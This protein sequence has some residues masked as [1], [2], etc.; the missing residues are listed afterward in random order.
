[1]GRLIRNRIVAKNIYRSNLQ[2]L[3]N[4]LKVER[5]RREKLEAEKKELEK[6]L[7]AEKRET[8]RLTRDLKSSQENTK[9]EMR[10]TEELCKKERE[11][12]MKALNPSPGKPYDELKNTEAMKER[13]AKAVTAMRNIAGQP[14]SR[15]FHHVNTHLHETGT[16]KT[17]LTPY[18]GL[19]LYH[20]LNFTRD[21]YD[22]LKRWMHKLGI[23]DPFPSKGSITKLEKEVADK[24]LYTVG[25]EEVVKKDGVRKKVDFVRLNNLQQF[26]NDK[27]QNLLDSGNLKFDRSTGDTIWL[28]IIGDKGSD[29]SKLCASIGNVD[30]PN[31]Y[32]HLVP[33]GI[34]TDDDTAENIARY[35]GPV[36]EQLNQLD[37][38]EVELEGRRARIPV[39]QYLVG[40]MKLVY[41]C[42]G[43]QGCQSTCSCIFCYRS[44]KTKIRDY[45]RGEDWQ[46]RTLES[47]VSDSKKKGK[48]TSNVK[49]G[50]SILFKKVSMEKVVPSSLHIAMGLGQT[51]GIN[52][53]KDLADKKDS[54]SAQ[55]LPKKTPK[56]KKEARELVEKEERRMEFCEQILDSFECV[57]TA[58]D[59]HS[60]QMVDDADLEDNDCR[61]QFCVFRDRIMGKEQYYHPKIVQC[62][63]CYKKHHA[64]CIGMWKEKDFNTCDLSGS[65]LQCF[66]CRGYSLPRLMASVASHLSFLK[67]ER[68]SQ[69]IKLDDV[70]EKY[71]EKLALW[72]G[73]GKT[74]REL[75]RIWRRWGADISAHKQDFCGNHLL[76]LLNADAVDDYCSIL[77]Q[78]PELSH[79]KEFMKNLGKFQRLCVARE[80]NEE[81]MAD[82]EIAIEALWF[83]LQQYAGDMNVIPK[84][85]VLLEHTMPFVRKHSTL[86]KT[87]EQGVEALHAAFNRIKV[88][89]RND[90]VATRR[91]EYCFR[92]LLFQNHVSD[93]S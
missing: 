90:R 5:Q 17:R 88:R 93:F 71:E 53:L 44:G 62:M 31:N 45:K 83:H 85:H 13:T 69:K 47:Y 75:E 59:H 27:I 58:Y 8:A 50:S 68:D 80:M 25:S 55:S 1:M 28:A 92:F 10:R 33:L 60:V 86:A 42:V 89:F 56:N 11:K 30:K 26:F 61:A 77:D 38:V 91:L 48:A 49:E 19:R 70:C 20:D 51:Y 32:S 29:E 40:D 84:M 22:G 23:Y 81:E 52:V 4:E 54:S 21:G 73:F 78:T 67:S 72:S 15:F 6:A 3:S 2:L 74:R 36:V 12:T 79:L 35:L 7:R 14:S 82:M 16:Q 43:H 9:R 39:S 87:S 41:S 66:S 64:V 63:G 18:E 46:L 57:K 24:E 37:F 65:I 34:F 76:K